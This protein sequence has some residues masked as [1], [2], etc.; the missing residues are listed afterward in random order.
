ML[1]LLIAPRHG[2]HKKQGFEQFYCHVIQTSR[3]PLKNTSSQLV[4]SCVL[5][6]RC[7]VTDVVYRVITQQR[8]YVL[9][10]FHGYNNN[11]LFHSC[12]H[13]FIFIWG[14]TVLA[15]SSRLSTVLGIREGFFFFLN[16]YSEGWSPIE[17][18]RHC[19]HQLCQPRVIMIMKKLVE[20]LAG[21]TEVLGKTCPSVAF[22]TTNPTCH[23]R[24]RA[25]AAA[26]ESQGLTDWATAR[27]SAKVTFLSDVVFG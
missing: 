1:V 16:S 11:S 19:S 5:E 14:F 20:S 18:I 21:E 24:T 4:H 7:P 17:S 25:Q 8:F 12:V 9:Q 10:F 2:S 15:L 6:I 13:L 27:P 3:V 26:V 23:A 22:S